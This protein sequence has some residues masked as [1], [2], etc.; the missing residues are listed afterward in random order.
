MI[1]GVRRNTGLETELFEPKLGRADRAMLSIIEGAIV[2]YAKAGIDGVTMDEIAKSSGV[3]RSLVIHYFKTQREVFNLAVKHIRLEFQRLAIRS[4]QVA[5]TPIAKLEAYV[6][7]TFQW[8]EKHPKHARVWLL[9][10]YGCSVGV[11]ERA[12]NTELS[13]IGQT[14][15]VALLEAVGTAGLERSQLEWKAKLI[16]IIIS[17]ALLTA[18][19][20]NHAISKEGLR[21]HTI[22]S[23][24][25]LARQLPKA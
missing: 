23:V 19:T 10:L 3:S 11:K 20:E 6:D 25:A 16:Q 15:I 1:S 8:I 24:L 17:G 13:D 2:C 22:A 4:I 5:D 14:R 21:S 9:H 7:S 18:L 12:L